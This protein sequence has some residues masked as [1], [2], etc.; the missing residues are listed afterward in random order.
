MPCAAGDP[1]S[2]GGVPVQFPIGSE[3]RWCAQEGVWALYATHR[4]YS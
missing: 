2:Y 4:H 3:I 1:H